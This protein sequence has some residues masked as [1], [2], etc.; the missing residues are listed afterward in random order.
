MLA[1]PLSSCIHTQLVT[2]CRVLCKQN[3]NIEK[4]LLLHKSRRHNTNYKTYY[5]NIIIIWKYSLT[6]NFFS[7][8]NVAFF[9]SFG[10]HVT[11]CSRNN[12]TFVTEWE[13]GPGAECSPL[14]AIKHRIF[15]FKIY[16]TIFLFCSSVCI[17]CLKTN[18]SRNWLASQKFCN[19]AK[20]Q[21]LIRFKE[22]NLV[23]PQIWS[24]LLTSDFLDF[25]PFANLGTV[26]KDRAF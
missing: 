21:L 12:G 26:W 6:S 22:F 7:R 2:I 13:S 3:I 4:F 23:R 17:F 15:S 5:E 11:H 19:C 8:P 10:V 25:K 1:T 9:F 14:T 24:R 18:M 16:L 20:M